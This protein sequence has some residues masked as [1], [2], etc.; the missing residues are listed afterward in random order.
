VKAYRVVRCSGSHIVW[1]ISSQMP[2][3]FQALCTP[4]ALYSPE[5]YFFCFCYR[6][7]KP[8]GLVQPEGDNI[9]FKI[10]NDLTGAQT[11]NL[12][13][14]S[15]VPQLLQGGNLISCIAYMNICILAKNINN[16][17]QKDNYRLGIYVKRNSSFRIGQ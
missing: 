16:T 3:R 12:L 11:C 6:L 15:T 7:S 14:C 1:T 4:A 5:T 2:M 10:F 13:A 8:H 9:Q 17:Q